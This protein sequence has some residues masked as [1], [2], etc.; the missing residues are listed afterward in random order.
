MPRQC[1][2]DSLALSPPGWGLAIRRDAHGLECPLIRASMWAADV[3]F[4]QQR[5][6]QKRKPRPSTPPRQQLDILG[7][8]LDTPS[9]AEKIASR[10][11]GKNSGI[12]WDL[13]SPT[14]CCRSMWLERSGL[15]TS[16]RPVAWPSTAR[17][18]NRTRRSAASSSRASAGSLGCLDWSPSLR[19][20]PDRL[21]RGARPFARLSR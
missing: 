14:Q 4:L 3:S 13:R 21:M 15:L 19:L 9:P 18:T 1:L 16:S 6:V 2:D 20:A 11:R 12:M 7:E 5:P 8:G 17:R 10:I